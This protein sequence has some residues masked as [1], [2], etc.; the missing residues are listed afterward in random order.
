MCSTMLIKFTKCAHYAHD[1][2]HI[3]T[4]VFFGFT[5]KEVRKLFFEIW[6]FGNATLLPYCCLLYSMEEDIFRHSHRDFFTFGA[7][8]NHLA[9]TQKTYQP[10][11]T[12]Y[13]LAKPPEHLQMHIATPWQS[14]K[15]ADGKCFNVKKEI[16]HHRTK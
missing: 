16:S 6:E 12:L 7:E 10:P 4:D 11:R 1:S 5:L 15:S 9:T 3:E 14:S 8:S 2:V 13:Q